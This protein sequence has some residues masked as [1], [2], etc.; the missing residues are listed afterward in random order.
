VRD[1]REEEAWQ[2]NRWQELRC[3][4]LALNIGRMSIFPTNENV[5]SDCE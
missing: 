3:N 2:Y 1:I 5:L 4:D